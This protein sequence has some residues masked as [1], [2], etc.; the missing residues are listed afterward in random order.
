MNKRY[1]EVAVDSLHLKD[2]EVVYLLNNNQ[3]FNDIPNVVV[4]DLQH[5]KSALV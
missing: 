3:I 5:V 2:V 1:Q 4:C